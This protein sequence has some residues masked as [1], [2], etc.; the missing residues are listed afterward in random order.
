MHLVKEGKI[1]AASFGAGPP[2]MLRAG[3]EQ[4]IAQNIGGHYFQPAPFS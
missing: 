4:Q 1:K 2:V 3:K